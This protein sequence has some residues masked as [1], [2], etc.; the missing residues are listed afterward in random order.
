[1]E[2]MVIYD[3]PAGGDR[4]D[5]FLGPAQQCIQASFVSPNPTGDFSRNAPIPIVPQQ[6]FRRLD[7]KRKSVF[8]D[9][10]IDGLQGADREGRDAP[11][12]KYDQAPF[13]ES[14]LSLIQG[15]N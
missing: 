7:D 1:M 14:A 6:K 15:F 13:G 4:S 10:P 11:K 5:V 9:L 3:R 8:S 12:K 2:N